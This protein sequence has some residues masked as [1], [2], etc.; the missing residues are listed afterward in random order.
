MTSNNTTR[1]HNH[2]EPTELHRKFY[3][4]SRESWEWSIANGIDIL[5]PLLDTMLHRVW[6]NGWEGNIYY[7]PIADQGV[8]PQPILRRTVDYIIARLADNQSV[9]VFCFGG[10]G[11]TGYIAACVMGKLMPKL[12]D[13]IEYVRNKYCQEAVESMAQVRS[14]AEFL[15]KPAI[16]DMYAPKPKPVE[17][18]TTTYTTLQTA[19]Q[20]SFGDNWSWHDYQH[21]KRG[22]HAYN[23]KDK[24][25]YMPKEDNQGDDDKWYMRELREAEKN[26]DSGED[27]ED[28]DTPLMGWG[29]DDLDEEEEEEVWDREDVEAYLDIEFGEGTWDWLVETE[30]KEAIRHRCRHCTLKRRNKRLQRRLK[31]QGRGK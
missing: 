11:R 16:A 29:R 22:S 1:W 4:G 26:L 21:G 7:T 6:S 25:W 10:H 30:I 2:K 13:P 27:E 15:D 28:K 31:R 3:V 24:D 5:V 8:L 23:D 9:H 19:K 17:P 20:G 18:H 12:E 14:I